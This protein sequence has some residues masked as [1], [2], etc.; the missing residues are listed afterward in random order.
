MQNPAFLDKNP[1]V[2]RYRLSCTG[3]G[4]QW[5]TYTGTGPGCNGTSHAVGNLY[6]YMSRVYLK[7]PDPD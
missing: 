2:Y 4:M 5:V 1:R 6:R 3:T 7:D